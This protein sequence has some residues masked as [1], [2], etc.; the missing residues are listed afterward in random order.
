[1]LLHL[2]P[3]VPLVWRDPTT[4]QLGV[5][6]VA[7]VIPDVSS[8]LERLVAVLAA[9]VSDT[10]YSMLAATFGV[11]A[12][13]AQRLRDAV[14]ASLLQEAVEPTPLRAAVLGDSP[15]AHGVARLLD[16]LGLRTGDLESPDLVVL[17]AD[18]VIPPSD[19]RGWLQ[20]D[21][22]HLPVV[23]SD[24]AITVGHVV[25]PGAT[26][27]L[28]CIDL[29]RRDADP[30]WPAIAAQLTMLAPPA[31]DPLRT[32]SAA[33][34]TARIV[35]R[36]LRHGPAASR[37]LRIAGDGG[38]VTERD[39]LPHPECRCATPQE[40]D[41][42]PAGVPAAPPPTTTATTSAVRA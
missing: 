16:E 24:A 12:R 27:C 4:L 7:A 21:I 20:R 13:D 33:V 22:P 41:W 26:A 30:A 8:G 19:H 40:N 34:H 1:M 31:G 39:V 36:R 23:A 42:A 17:V 25:E 11:S 2:D 29:H 38:E 37:E 15:L 5:D 28:H 14:T 9:G 35:A 18:R 10:G 6:P 3:A 32:A